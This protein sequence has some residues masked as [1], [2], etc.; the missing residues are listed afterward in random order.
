MQL[1]VFIILTLLGHVGLF[2][3]FQKAG[4]K[5]AWS[6]FVPVWNKLVWLEIIG[7]PKWRY[8]LLW[9]PI[10]N[11]FVLASM[12]IELAMSF[13]KKSFGAHFAAVTFAPAYL[14]YL[15]FSNQTTESYV[16]KGY[17]IERENPTAKGQ[18]REWTEAII[19]A[20][21]AATFIRMFLF[22]MYTIPT[23]SMEGSLLVGDFLVVSKVN[24]GSRAP[25]TPIQLPLVHNRLPFVDGESYSKIV[26]WPYLRTPKLERVERFDPVV[27][28]FPEGDTIAIGKGM[29][30]VHYQNNYTNYYSLRHIYG[31]DVVDNKRFFE[32]ITRPIDKRD[33]Y[34]KRCVGL[35]GET[36][37][38]KN[39]VVFI[40]DKEIEKPEKLQFRYDVATTGG[41]NEATLKKWDI[42][43]TTDGNSR[44]GNNYQLHLNDRQV[45]QLKG[46]NGVLRVEPTPLERGSRIFPN[47]TAHYNWTYDNFGP[48]TIPAKGDVI[49]LS[50]KN[51]AI[52]KRIIGVYEGHDLSIKGDKIFIDGNE[53][54]SYTIEMDY[55][56]MM[57]D[58]RHNSEDSRVWGFV[59]EDHVVGKPLFIWFSNKNGI[60]WNRLFKAASAM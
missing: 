48:L 33:N 11:L 18:I 54:T 16:G 55:Y 7:R 47:D 9:I 50:P 39:R 42:D 59:P 26:E 45:E 40:D 57:G 6:A 22:E 20:V 25:M 56:F 23:P 13:N 24:Y 1:T 19:F 43:M 17:L 3:I 29:Y 32:T 51:I 37:K 8:A 60:R 27:F 34:I 35:P 30:S 5:N 2:R 58:N 36:I 49:E 38:I 41:I 46:L 12:L 28:N 15:G 44:D 52:Y 31:N 4:V 10:V 14:L 53:A 21:F